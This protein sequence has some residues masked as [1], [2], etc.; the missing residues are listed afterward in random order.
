LA[1]KDEKI[2]SLKIGKDVFKRA[3]NSLKFWKRIFA[4]EISNFLEK[5]GLL[6]NVLPN[7][8][9]GFRRTF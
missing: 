1:L 9:G 7:L 4:P 8:D 5:V 6:K 2:Q 3:T